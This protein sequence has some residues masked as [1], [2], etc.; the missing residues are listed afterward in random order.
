MWES[1]QHHDQTTAANTVQLPVSTLQLPYLDTYSEPP[2]N[3]LCNSGS[4]RYAEHAT[5]LHAANSHPTAAPATLLSHS[6]CD[7]SC[8][9]HCLPICLPALT[10]PMAVSKND[11]CQDHCNWKLLICCCCCLLSDLG[12]VS[13]VY[14]LPVRIIAG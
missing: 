12:T 6:C 11:D 5:S 1:F 9:T 14:C 10:P 8:T 13:T 7:F 4:I 3:T 2:L